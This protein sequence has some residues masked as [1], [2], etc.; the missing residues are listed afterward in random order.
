MG[1]RVSIFKD[2]GSGMRLQGVITAKA[3]R[4]FKL[5]RMRLAKIAERPPAAIS[6]AEVIEYLVR[7]EEETVRYI[8][9][10]T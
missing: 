1:G 8:E 4:L 3:G 7:G 9:R 5:H 6:H 2:K 10:H